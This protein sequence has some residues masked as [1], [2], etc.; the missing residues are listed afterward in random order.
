M[1]NSERLQLIRAALQET[2]Q[3]DQVVVIRMRGQYYNIELDNKGV[4]DFFKATKINLL[5]GFQGEKLSDPETLSLFLHILLQHEYP[6]MTIDQVDSLIEFRRY[7]YI[8]AK[9]MECLQVF[10]PDMSGIDEP[11]PAEPTEDGETLPQ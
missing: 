10:W 11:E 4:K 2:L 5:D 8:R 6:E 9:I 3:V 1:A 7:P